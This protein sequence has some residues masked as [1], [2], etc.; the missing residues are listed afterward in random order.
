MVLLIT[1]D[2]DD[3]ESETKLHDH[4]KVSRRDFVQLSGFAVGGLS[5]SS[6][7]SWAPLQPWTESRSAKL[8]TLSI[9]VALLTIEGA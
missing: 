1:V 4:M 3:S 2:S 7:L 9:V 5:L 6:D 8:R